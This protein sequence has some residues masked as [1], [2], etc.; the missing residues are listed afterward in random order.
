MDS[1]IQEEFDKRQGDIDVIIELVELLSSGSTI[2]ILCDNGDIKTLDYEDRLLNSLVSVISL[3]TYNQIEST[4][5][6]GLE[7]LYDDIADNSISYE[8]L[9]RD[10]QKEVLGGILSKYTSGKKLHEEVQG[11]LNLKVPSLSLNIRKIFNGNIDSSKI[12]NIRDAYGIA[13]DANPEYRNGVEVTYFK[14]ARNDLAH[15]NISFSEYG[16]VNPH[17]EII[18]KSKRVSGYLKSVISGFNSYIES[19]GYRA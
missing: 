18:S 5:R 7:A 12:Y 6:G 3:V 14:D 13:L 9:R 17:S 10:I 15:G 16:S 4:M 1:I 8:E 11:S 2:D 19:K